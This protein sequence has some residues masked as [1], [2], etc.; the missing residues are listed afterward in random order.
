VFDARTFA[1][2]VLITSKQ[3]G[4]QARSAGITPL[5]RYGA[6]SSV[7]VIRQTGFDHFIV[8]RIYVGFVK[9]IE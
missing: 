7:N 9:K 6:T 2:N 1:G 5:G 3:N 8:R 4:G